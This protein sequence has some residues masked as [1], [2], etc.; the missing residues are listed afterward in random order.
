MELQLALPNLMRYMSEVEVEVEVR[1]GR[2]AM[3]N[4]RKLGRT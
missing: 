2:N 3:C 1:L 4:K